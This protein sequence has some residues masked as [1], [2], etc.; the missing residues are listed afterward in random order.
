MND[1]SVIGDA[2]FAHRI[3]GSPGGKYCESLQR[4]VWR[5]VVSLLKR[6]VFGHRKPHFAVI[7]CDALVT[8]V[9]ALKFQVSV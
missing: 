6:S 4:K 3:M 7:L 5:G 9:G 2:C 8:N 1:F